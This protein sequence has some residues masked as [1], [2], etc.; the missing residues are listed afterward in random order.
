M[1]ISFISTRISGR[2]LVKAGKGAAARR[3]HPPTV[4]TATVDTQN[5]LRHRISY[6]DAAYVTRRARPDHTIG[7]EIWV[8]ITSPGEA[9]PLDE[10]KYR[11]VA[12]STASPFTI[13]FNGKD[14]AKTA[15]YRLRWM[16]NGGQKSSWGQITSATI[17]G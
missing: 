1:A 6:R 17:V 9:R 13:N 12:L 16:L 14:A 3:S 5:R 7:C 15:H 2:F 10:E 11:N 4:S 8:A